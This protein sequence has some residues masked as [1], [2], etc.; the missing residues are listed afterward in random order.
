MSR[1]SKKKE[2][3]KMKAAGTENMEKEYHLDEAEENLDELVK[4][5][6]EN[7]GKKDVKDS[8][9]EELEKKIEELEAQNKEY[10]NNWLRAMADFDNYRKRI[11][12]E[13]QNS[14]NLAKESL[15]L[16]ILRVIDNFERALESVEED[17]SASNFHTGIEMIYRQMKDILV[18]ENIEAIDA[19]G[20]EFDPNFHEALLH[21]HDENYGENIIC[22]VIQKGYLYNNKLLRAARV[23][24]SKGK[25]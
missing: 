23:A 4:K 13:K 8:D 15:F 10:Y 3:E 14:I 12:K 9:L 17:S 19:L 5:A 2:R 6:M 18:N 22:Q 24:V 21:I 11:A 7:E 20:E 25:E 16:E 1:R